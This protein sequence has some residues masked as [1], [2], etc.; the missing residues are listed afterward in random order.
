MTIDTDGKLWV[1]FFF[2]GRVVQFDPD[3]GLQKNYEV[4][5]E[6]IIQDIKITSTLQ[7]N[8]NSY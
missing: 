2:G 1:A 6:T 8:M 7:N 3:T 5:E 4:R